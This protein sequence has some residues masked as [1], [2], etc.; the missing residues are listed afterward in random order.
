MEPLRRAPAEPLR[1]CAAHE[2]S[3]KRATKGS[4]IEDTHGA[5]A[6][7]DVPD[8]GNGAGADG[9]NGGRRATGKD[10]HDDEH[11]NG[12]GHG[13]EDVPEQEQG[14]GEDVDGAAARGFAERG[15]P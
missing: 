4:E 9:L 6:F 14:K 8:V 11:G 7:L 5:A 3:Q 12:A 15:P 2:R 13:G 1:E 10:A